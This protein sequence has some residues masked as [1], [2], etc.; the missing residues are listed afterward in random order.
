VK[1]LAMVLVVAAA[2]GGGWLC[3][4][5]N[6][7]TLLAGKVVSVDA[8][9]KSFVVQPNTPSGVADA[10][11]QVTVATDA[12]THVLLDHKASDFSAL[13]VG[14]QVVVRPPKGTAVA[15]DCKPLPTASPA[16]SHSPSPS[17]SPSASH[18]STGGGHSST[19]SHTPTRAPT[20]VHAPA[21][22]HGTSSHGTVTTH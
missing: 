5:E 20:P 17:P 19:P 21:P 14:M 18:T 2:L 8:N 4:E 7:A 10:N 16:P 3:A 9:Q 22:A 1:K 15:V 11:L 13:A 12:N 6:V